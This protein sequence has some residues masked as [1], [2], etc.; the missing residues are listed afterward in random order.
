MVVFIILRSLEKEIEK[1][2][3]TLNIKNHAIIHIEHSGKNHIVI[4]GRRRKYVPSL[5]LMVGKNT[6]QACSCTFHSINNDL[7]AFFK[8]QVC[9]TYFL[10]QLDFLIFFIFSDYN[11]QPHDFKLQS[12]FI[13]KGTNCFLN[14]LL[15][16]N[17][18]HY[19]FFDASFSLFLAFSLLFVQR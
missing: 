16:T 7:Q 10:C 11:I 19:K 13:K 15:Y 3:D 5:S 2:L 12:S 14:F 8:W 9:D 1:R 18:T 17:F 6:W 4:S